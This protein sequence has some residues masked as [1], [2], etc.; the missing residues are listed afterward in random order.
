MKQTSLF[1]MGIISFSITA[2]AQNWVNGGNSLTADGTFGIKSNFS[3][4]FQTNNTERGRITSNGLWGFGTAKPTAKVHINSTASKDPLNVQVSGTTK[5]LVHSDG[6]VAVGAFAVPPANG[7]YVA[8]NTG[9]GT[10]TPQNTL[11]VF[12]GSSGVVG[13][14]DAPLL[15]ENSTHSYV[16]ILAPDAN[17]TGVLFGR[18]SAGLPGGN[19]DGGIIY[20]SVSTLRGF[21]FRTNGNIVQMVLTDK[22][23]LGVG[24]AFPGENRMR[25]TLDN[26]ENGICLE[27]PSAGGK[28]HI[29]PGAITGDLFLVS[30]DVTVG[31]FNGIT[32]AYA[33]LS[34]ERQK[35][36]IKP[37]PDMLENIRRLKPSVYQFKNVKDTMKYNGFIAQ[38]VMKLFPSMVSHTV[39]AAQN[40]D[41]YLMD[42][43]QFGVL[44]IKGIQELMSVID[45]R[46]KR[47]AIMENDYNTKIKQLEKQVGELERLLKQMMDIKDKNIAVLNNA[48]LE[49]NT[50][51][52]FKNNTTVRYKA[53]VSSK[54]EI[55][56]YNQQ[57]NVVK[58]IPANENGQSVIDAKYMTPGTYTYSLLVNGNPVGT[59]RMIVVR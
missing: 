29:T 36:N 20:N 59:K 35:I 40:V 46:E 27:R 51:N 17:E 25:L 52:P 57:G 26:S 43:S 5:L 1:L 28:W 4:L 8:G 22:G 16:N 42:Y 56:V 12:K 10:A 11:H 47:T 21:Q 30:Q 48:S 9:I 50:P 39:S 55:V 7:L 49:Q 45:E 41:V 31:R 54:G 14:Y 38:D 2:S 19:V 23:R 18:P 53:P 33:A 37:M 58:K 6:G 3:L 24:T 15:V 44:A 32:G 34:D 13:Y